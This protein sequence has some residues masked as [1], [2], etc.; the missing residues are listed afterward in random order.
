MSPSDE[1][2]DVL[3]RTVAAL[4]RL[5]AGDPEPFNA[6][7]SQ[8]ADV[9]VFGGFGAYE[10]GWERVCQ[11]TAWAASR[12]HGGHIAVEPLAAGESGDLAYAIWIERG[13]ARVAG[14]DEPAPLVLRVTHIFRREGGAWALLHRHGDPVTEKTEAMAVLQRE[15]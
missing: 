6:L 3:D 15:P 4:S 1:L 13:E 7:W 8:S 9:T 10:R 14:R 5:V 12:F 2:R 11:N